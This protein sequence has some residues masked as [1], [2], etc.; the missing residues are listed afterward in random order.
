MR[1]V[2]HYTPVMSSESR[3]AGDIVVEAEGVFR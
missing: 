2:G 3:L 1:G